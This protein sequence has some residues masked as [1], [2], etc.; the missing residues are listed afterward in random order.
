MVARRRSSLLRHHVANGVA[1]CASCHYRFHNH[2]SRTGW[3]KFAE[4]R[5]ADLKFLESEMNKTHR[6]GLP[7]YRE[8]LEELKS[9]TK[10]TGGNN[11]NS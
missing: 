7:Y 6:L 9:L 8:K 1:L 4:Q 11:D 10:T 2:E 3:Q 5:P